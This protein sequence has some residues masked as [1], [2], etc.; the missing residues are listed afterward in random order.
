[1]SG[2][3]LWHGRHLRARSLLQQSEQRL[4][5]ST[6]A[7]PRTKRASSDEETSGVLNKPYRPLEK[8]RVSSSAASEVGLQ[9]PVVKADMNTRT[10]PP[11]LAQKSGKRR[12]HAASGLP[13]ATTALAGKSL[14]A[15]ADA[16]LAS[17]RSAP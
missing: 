8:Q 7:I 13:C 14:S 16:A 2:H 6:K 4:S 17:S 15:D 3:G 9:R 12:T 1:M 5:L 10:N 11:R